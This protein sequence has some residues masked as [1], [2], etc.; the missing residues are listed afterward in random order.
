M[1][2]EFEQACG[3]VRAKDR[4]SCLPDDLI[5]EIL[6]K[7]TLKEAIKTS[8]LSGRWKT[9]WASHPILDFGCFNWRHCDSYVQRVSNILN[10]F[11]GPKLH[12]L[13]IV[14]PLSLGILDLL[15]MIGFPLHLGIVLPK[16]N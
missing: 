4:I 16:L 8:I 6:S 2:C 13:K 11:N 14:D 9:A 15:F 12:T 10:Q 7:L 1:F 3:A 5:A